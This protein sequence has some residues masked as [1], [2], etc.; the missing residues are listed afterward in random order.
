MVFNSVHFVLFF[1]VVYAL[2]RALP[3]RAQN[4]LLLLSSY[5]FYGAW[6]WRFLGL[7]IGSTIVDYFCALY[8]S[9][10][11]GPRQRRFALIVSLGF[12]LTMLGF[13][14]YF[15]FFAESLQTLAGTAGWH[16]DTVT[17]R[18]VL[19]IGISFYTFMT[20]SYVID[21]YRR[22]I[23]PTRHP[24]DFAVFVAYFP[25]LVAGPILRAAALIPQIARPRTITRDHL[26]EGTWLVGYGLSVVT[27]CYMRRYLRFLQELLA[28]EQGTAQLSAE[29]AAWLSDTASALERIRPWL[30]KGPV[31][32][33]QRSVLYVQ[34]TGLVDIG[35]L[36]GNFQD[37]G[38]AA[39]DVLG[40]V[41]NPSNPDLGVPEPVAAALML[42][43]I[44]PLLRR[45]SR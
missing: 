28:A 9:S 29:V 17:L 7:L 26:V 36:V 13:F 2:Y 43:G 37:F 18:V 25:H 24:L 20:M 34:T 19:P 39:A 22:D 31:G 14:K 12:N 27:L 11:Q 16:L 21:V 10:R 15:N 4:W 3:H 1:V 45:R 42:V 35:T 23:E 32:A 5:Y 38:G 44:V 6:D 30:G 41:D 8:I 33:G 40:P